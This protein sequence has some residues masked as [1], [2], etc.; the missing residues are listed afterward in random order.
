MDKVPGLHTSLPREC[1]NSDQLAVPTELMKTQE[2]EGIGVHP[3]GVVI[4]MEMRIKSAV[5]Y[6]TCMYEVP[7]S[8]LFFLPQ[9]EAYN[10]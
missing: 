8:F 6:F 10:S 7:L 5:T 4:L 2:R 3:N 9:E 1:A